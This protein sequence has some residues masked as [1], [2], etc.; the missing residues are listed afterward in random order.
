MLS[1]AAE[2]AV[3][4]GS[5]FTEG[6]FVAFTTSVIG[7]RYTERMVWKRTSDA[8]ETGHPSCWNTT[9]PIQGPPSTM[10]YSPCPLKIISASEVMQMHIC[11]TATSLV[12]GCTSPSKLDSIWYFQ[13]GIANPVTVP[14][15]W[16]L[17]F[18]PLDPRFPVSTV[19][20]ASLKC[21]QSLLGTAAALCCCSAFWRRGGVP[22][23]RWSCGRCCCCGRCC[24]WRSCC[25]CW[26]RSGSPSTALPFRLPCPL[27]GRLALP[28][29][30]PGCFGQVYFLLLDARV[31]S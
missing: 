16:A 19:T 13:Y 29:S 3:A 24:P 28:H 4:I 12:S 20:A 31:Q 11:G 27:S 8:F 1:L 26:S 15:V 21:R 22:P 9:A 17:S 14:F 5:C 7:V 10:W 6:A 30:I 2:D 23:C 25:M 18:A